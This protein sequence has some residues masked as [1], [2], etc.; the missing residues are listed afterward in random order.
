MAGRPWRTAGFADLRDNNSDDV[1]MPDARAGVS[2]LPHS[3]RHQREGGYGVTPRPP[4]STP[5]ARAS[6]KIDGAVFTF[7]KRS[8]APPEDAERGADAQKQEKVPYNIGKGLKNQLG[9]DDEQRRKKGVSERERTLAFMKDIGEKLYKSYDAGTGAPDKPSGTQRLRMSDLFSREDAFRRLKVLALNLQAWNVGASNNDDDDDGEPEEP[10]EPEGDQF[11]QN[12]AL[13]YARNTIFSARVGEIMQ[14]V[15]RHFKAVGVELPPE[16]DNVSAGEEDAS[17]MVENVVLL[18]EFY[19]LILNTESQLTA[20]EPKKG[21]LSV[22]DVARQE[23]PFYPILAEDEKNLVWAWIKSREEALHEMYRDSTYTFAMKVAGKIN[24]GEFGVDKLISASHRQRL[25]SAEFESMPPAQYDDPRI[26]S[27]RAMLLDR[28]IKMLNALQESKIAD[29]KRQ[30][31]ANNAAAV[32][33]RE[34]PGGADAI[35]SKEEAERFRSRF[36]TTYEIFDE[37]S[38]PSRISEVASFETMALS[39]KTRELQFNLDTI[40]RSLKG[41]DMD[42]SRKRLLWA[43]DWMQRPEVLQ[44]GDLT[45]LFLGALDSALFAAHEFAPN[46]RNVDEFDAFINS[47]SFDVVSAF[48]ELVAIQIMRSKFYAPTKTQL[49]RM[50]QRID[51]RA[52]GLL[53]IFAR[54]FYDRTSKTVKDSRTSPTGAS[55]TSSALYAF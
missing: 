26:S 17:D 11:Y 3:S 44:H 35:W 34:Q 31:R 42:N 50:G 43:T 33:R 28:Y 9:H 30:Q 24:M 40:E 21:E 46:L 38:L 20:S 16:D 10:E 37:D 5:D 54:F 53:K 48:A 51:A 27:E 7:G 52:R 14:R 8:Q 39:P 41:V 15:I 19:D 12:L 47:D 29:L 32:V 25:T 45:P 6:G 13:K 49:D 36:Q 23:P 55:C 1:E 22:G 2:R 4:P 18:K